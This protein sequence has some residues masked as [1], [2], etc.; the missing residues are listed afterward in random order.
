[1][2]RGFFKT[3]LN[4]L[5]KSGRRENFPQRGTKGGHLKPPRAFASGRAPRRAHE[6]EH[7]LYIWGWVGDVLWIYCW[8]AVK[9]LWI[10][11]W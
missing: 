4:I 9:R 1:M 8:Y 3:F 11:C 2:K 10:S 7:L 6:A 5:C